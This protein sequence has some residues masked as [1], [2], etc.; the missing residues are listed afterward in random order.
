MEGIFVM[1][2]KIPIRQNIIVTAHESG[3]LKPTLELFKCK[4]ISYLSVFLEF[5]KCCT[6]EMKHFH[7]VIN[8]SFHMCR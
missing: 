2:F 6:H 8:I 7:P 3:F 5:C 1:P 4:Q